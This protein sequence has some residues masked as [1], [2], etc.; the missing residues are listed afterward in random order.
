[1]AVTV[2]LVVMGVMDVM[3]LAFAMAVTVAVAATVA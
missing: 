3:V 2:A 1:M